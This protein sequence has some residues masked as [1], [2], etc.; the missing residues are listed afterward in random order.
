[1]MP[2]SFKKVPNADYKVPDCAYGAE[3]LFQVPNCR[4]GAQKL[5][6]GVK[7]NEKCVNSTTMPTLS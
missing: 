3:I 2:N 6:Y 5:S 1:M 4:E 7:F